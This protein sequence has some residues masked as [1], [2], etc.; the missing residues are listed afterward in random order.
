MLLRYQHLDHEA[1]CCMQ[2][3]NRLVACE[4][5]PPPTLS[6]DAFDRKTSLRGSAVR[7]MACLLRA[8]AAPQRTEAC[9]AR[10]LQ[11][12][13]ACLRSLT[14]TAVILGTGR[15]LRRSRS[16]Q[17]SDQALGLGSLAGSHPKLASTQQCASQD[18]AEV[19]QSGQSFRPSEQGQLGG[20]LAKKMRQAARTFSCKA[21]PKPR[22]VGR[23]ISPALPLPLPLD[24]NLWGRMDVVCV[25]DT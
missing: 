8:A 18:S 10:H 1:Q 16:G 11:A 3:S 22:Q 19:L 4:E 21:P 7:A 17:P 6:I 23:P 25:R 9:L 14:T 24:L 2:Q 20:A 12:D 15:E 5:R 13:S